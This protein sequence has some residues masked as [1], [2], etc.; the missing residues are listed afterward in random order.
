MFE[1]VLNMILNW[2][3][4]L[5]MFHFKIKLNVKVTDNL[6]LGKTKKKEPNEVQ[7][8]EVATRGVL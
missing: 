5:K 7:N 4:K 2:L 3:P 8:A 6:L 1:K